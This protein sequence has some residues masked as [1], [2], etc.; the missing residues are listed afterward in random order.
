MKE[1]FINVNPGFIKFWGPKISGSEPAPDHTEHEV[2]GRVI[3][4]LSDLARAR[5]EEWLFRVNK[6]PNI[7]STDFEKEFAE[8][9]AEM[10]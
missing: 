5:K 3:S 4:C 7:V 9:F 2:L 1:V 10:E 6:A 8:D